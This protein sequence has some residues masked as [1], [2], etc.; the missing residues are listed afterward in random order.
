MKAKHPAK[1]WIAMPSFTLNTPD[2]ATMGHAVSTSMKALADAG[3]TGDMV[4]MA[5]HSLGG[6]MSQKYVVGHT[7]TI[8]GLMLMGSVLTR[9]RHSTNDDGTT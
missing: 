6:V 9:D 4:L 8:K 7:D 5:G 2:P 1:V 3:F